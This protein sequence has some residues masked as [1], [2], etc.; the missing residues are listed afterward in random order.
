MKKGYNNSQLVHLRPDFYE[1]RS[2]TTPIGFFELTSN[3]NIHGSWWQYYRL[4]KAVVL[5]WHDANFTTTRPFQK[6]KS[7]TKS[8][9]I[10]MRIGK[11]MAFF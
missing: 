7:V 9:V 4:K 10:R 11:F 8:K 3:M 5:L 6:M 2:Q 1:R